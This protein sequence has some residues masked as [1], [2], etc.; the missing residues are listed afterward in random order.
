MSRKVPD[1]WKKYKLGEIIE[2]L[3][4]KGLREQDRKPGN[5]PVYG[6]NGIIGYHNTPLVKGPGIIIGRVGSIGKI[7]Y[8]PVDFYPIDTA[9]YVNLKKHNIDM[10]F[11]YY[12]LFTLPMNKLNFQS[13]VPGLNRHIAYSLDVAI[14]PLSEQ[15]VIASIFPPIEDKI[16]LLQQENKTLEAMA[17]TIFQHLFIEK[18]KDNWPKVL[19]PEVVKIVIGKTP[20][21]EESYWFSTD[22]QNVKWAS[23]RDLGQSDVFIFDTSEYLTQEAIEKFKIPITP[24]GTVLLSFKLTVGRVRITDKPM[25]SNEAIAH[26]VFDDKTPFSK[27]YLYLF[28]RRL[29]YK[30]LGNTSSI[31]TAINS[32]IVK[33]IEITIPD[34]KTMNVFKT[35][36]DPLFSKIK[37]NDLQLQ[38]LTQLFDTLLHGLM[39]G[40]LRVDDTLCQ[41]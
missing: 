32:S 26:F 24:A 5:I 29:K 41:F 17:E 28:L 3:Y 31:A 21:R 13:A 22:P 35:Y 9:Y 19:L 23:I 1:G 20:P 37:E 36:I 18:A 14:P 34:N 6:S 4:G 38:T 11:L 39:S 40:K 33:N 7:N 12:L 16:K 10:K 15:R 27:E 2:L 25:A 8:S 30:S